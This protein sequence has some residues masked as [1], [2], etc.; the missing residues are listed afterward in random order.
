MKW[1]I[2]ILILFFSSLSSALIT[3]RIGVGNDIIGNDILIDYNG[4]CHDFDVYISSALDGCWDVK[5][6]VDGEIYNQGK[7]TS[8][9]FYV[10][11]ALC[12]NAKLKLRVYS[13]N[14]SVEAV[15]KLRQNNTIIE[16]PFV[17]KQECPSGLDDKEIVLAGLII[18]IFLFLVIL[19]YK[20]RI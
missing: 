10:K 2:L 6:D 20:K 15:A 7:W 12:R 8:T 11:D 14:E 13:N 19:W 18:F 9:F 17:I 1:L 5:I 16:K 3:G 4:K